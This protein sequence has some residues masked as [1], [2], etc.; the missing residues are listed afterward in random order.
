MVY[1]IRLTQFTVFPRTNGDSYN[2]C[3]RQAFPAKKPV[4]IVKKP[5]PQ[6]QHAQKQ[7]LP[8]FRKS[9]RDDKGRS[10]KPPAFPQL[11]AMLTRL[12]HKFA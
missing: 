1:V 12:D 11:A 3:S 6:A 10:M 7:L 8:V 4:K 5:Y 2:F 9:P